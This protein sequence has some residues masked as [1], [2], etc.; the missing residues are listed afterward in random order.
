MTEHLQLLFLVRENKR[1]GHMEC[2]GSEFKPEPSPKLT[3]NA[4]IM[5]ASHKKPG[6]NWRGSRIGSY[7]P[8]GMES[9]II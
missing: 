3:V 5:H 6:I 1:Y 4:S 7:D 9:I 8:K 2:D